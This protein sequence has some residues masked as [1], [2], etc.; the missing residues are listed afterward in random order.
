M[1]VSAP[2]PAKR[3]LL[4]ILLGLWLL[5]AVQTALYMKFL[6]PTRAA[7]EV[8]LP[9]PA[10]SW[11]Q[12]YRGEL[13]PAWEDYATQKLG[14]R[15]WLVEP[16]NQLQYS[17]LQQSTNTQ[18]VRGKHGMLFEVGPLQSALGR[19]APATGAQVAAQV[20]RLRAVQDTLARR[21]KLLVFVIAPSKPEL[22]PENLPDS[23]QRLPRRPTA[24]E[25]Y[26]QPMQAAGIN[27]LDLAAVFRAWKRSSPYPLFPSGGTHWSGYGFVRAADTL[28]QYLE[29]RGKLRLPRVRQTGLV[30]GAAPRYSDNDLTR[31]LNLLHDPAPTP[32][33]AY[34]EVAF[35]P[36]APGQRPPRL[37]LVGDSFG[38]SFI[39]FYPYLPQLSAPGSAYW[40][41]NHDV[42]WTNGPA[43][44]PG[45][46]ADRDLRADLANT[47]VVLL[48]FNASNL[49]DF[50]HG[51][52]ERAARELALGK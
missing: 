31:L 50:D 39:E 18:V 36:P 30:V 47:D 42:A 12:W 7:F 14:L 9:R 10:F 22:Y 44:G 28:M 21:G 24:Y 46:V 3:W 51:F 13:Q 37:L 33:L 41:Y 20:Q 29:A 16:Y 45:L 43:T 15:E 49:A 52:S 4:G 5:P 6:R 26:R 11:R 17:V 23:C 27:V 40:Y 1:E 38:W 2:S 32:P 8:K 34:P 35:D 48:L 19:I 25:R